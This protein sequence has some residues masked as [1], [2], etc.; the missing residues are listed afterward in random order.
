MT[1]RSFM[2][3]ATGGAVAMPVA[4]R[5][6]IVMVPKKYT[7]TVSAPIAMP[8]F[9]GGFTVYSPALTQQDID[10]FNDLLESS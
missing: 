6:A 10:H 5:T 8:P 1:R 2:K 7:M 4:T 3:A 9:T